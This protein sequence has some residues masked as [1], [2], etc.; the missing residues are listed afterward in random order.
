MSQKK[1][2]G[3]SHVLFLFLKGAVQILLI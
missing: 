1:G 2:H 3:E